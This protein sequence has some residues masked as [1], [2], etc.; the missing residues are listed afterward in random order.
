MAKEKK[1][2]V[3]WDGFE[4]GIFDTW[5]KCLSMTKGYKQAKFKSF[6]TLKSAK[7]AYSNNYFDYVGKTQ[8]F[9][10]KLSSEELLKIG[11]PI[12]NSISVDAACSGNPGIME[13]RGVMTD[14]K[15][16]L[17]INGPFEE[18]TNNIG[19]FLALVHGISLL[20]KN[21][22]TI[23]VYSDSRNAIGWIKQ[24]I[25]KTNLEKNK[26]NESLFEL[27]ARAE[28]WLQTNSF[29]NKIL[30]WETKAWG[31]I[32]ADFGRKK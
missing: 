11:K 21:N 2:Y 17:F 32:P 18:G 22:I 20:K 8:P 25:C 29:E 9:E 13:Y 10:T 23:P 27:I 26:K 15:E 30:K 19:E 7:E 4:T 14:T 12:L 3:V 31:E 5:A 24:K 28:E 1:F 16:Q 6:P